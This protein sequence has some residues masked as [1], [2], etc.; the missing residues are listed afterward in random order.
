MHYTE[1]CGP[2]SL[3]TEGMHIVKMEIMPTLLMIGVHYD[4]IIIVGCL[5]AFEGMKTVSR[6]F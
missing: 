1:Q 2:Q 5:V 3:N 4:T 6:L